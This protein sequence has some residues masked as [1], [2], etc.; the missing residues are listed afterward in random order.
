MRGDQH[1]DLVDHRAHLA[2]AAQYPLVIQGEQQGQGDLFDQLPECRRVAA[3]LPV[4]LEAGQQGGQGP[5]QRAEPGTDAASQPW[6]APGQVGQVLEQ[7]AVVGEALDDQVQ[8]QP[9]VLRAQ[10]HLLG[11]IEQRRQLGLEPLEQR[12]HQRFLAMEVVVE[13]A[14]ADAQFVGDLQC[15]DVGLA[16]FVEQQQ[17]A[18]EDSVACLHPDFFW[19]WRCPAPG[20]RAGSF[21]VYAR[22]CPGPLRGADARRCQG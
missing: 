11:R 13:I 20:A 10:A 22:R 15:R 18:F 4:G 21:S 6:Q 12:H 2:L 7:E 17:R 16:L 1:H 19:G 3:Q 8:E 14:R 9:V 5:L